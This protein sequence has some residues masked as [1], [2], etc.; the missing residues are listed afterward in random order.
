[1]LQRYGL[2]KELRARIQDAM[3]ES[4]SGPLTTSAN[5]NVSLDPAVSKAIVDKILGEFR[6]T[7]Q[8][9]TETVCSHRLCTV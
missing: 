7:L 1:V 6:T 2:T 9:L 3:A 8:Q 5:A 4:A